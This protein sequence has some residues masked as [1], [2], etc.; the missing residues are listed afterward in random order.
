MHVVLTVQTT[1]SEKQLIEHAKAAGIRVFGL[2]SYDVRK[3]ESSSPRIVIGFGG[4]SEQQIEEGIHQ[5]MASWK[6]NKTKSSS[7]L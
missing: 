6:I 5:I 1:L 3:S 4:L 7:S 2:H